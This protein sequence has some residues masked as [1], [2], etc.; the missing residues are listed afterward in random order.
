MGLTQ[1]RFVAFVFSFFARP[2][3]RKMA[4]YFV[5]CLHCIVNLIIFFKD[6]YIKLMLLAG[7]FFLFMMVNLPGYSSYQFSYIWFLFFFFFFF[8]TKSYFIVE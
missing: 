3:E 8:F 1:V 6:V 5:T 4:G 2:V 7:T